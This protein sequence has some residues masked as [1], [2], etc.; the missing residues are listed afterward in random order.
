MGFHSINCKGCSHPFL[1]HWV[2][3]P[4]N[5]WMQDVTVQY[6]DGRRL[7]GA[8]DGYGRVAGTGFVETDAHIHTPPEG[9][10]T[11]CWEAAG[12]PAFEGPSTW[13]DDQGYFFNDPDHDMVEPTTGEAS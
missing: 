10:H 11:S 4:V 13:A 9:W 5:R 2:T 1:S 6:E 12:R 3:N 7:Q 8:Y